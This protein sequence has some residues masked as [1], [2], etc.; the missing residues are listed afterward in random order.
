VCNTCRP[1]CKHGGVLSFWGFA[2]PTASQPSSLPCTPRRDPSSASYTHPS[3]L[4]CA[5]IGAAIMLQTKSSANVCRRTRKHGG[6]RGYWGFASPTASQPSSLPCAPGRDPSSASYTTPRLVACAAGGA[7]SAYSELAHLGL[8]T[9]PAAKASDWLQTLRLRSVAQTPELCTR[10]QDNEQH[11]QPP[12]SVPPPGGNVF[13][14]LYRE[15][16]ERDIDVALR[17]PRL[18]ASTAPV[19]LVKTDVVSLQRACSFAA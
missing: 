9:L 7:A 2:S 4:P 14:R 18:R 16:V 15:R 12:R 11:R 8:I 13:E 5:A 19:Q 6:V 1:A 3:R 10:K 17:G